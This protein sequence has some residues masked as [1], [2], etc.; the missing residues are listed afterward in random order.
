MPQQPNNILIIRLSSLGDV[1]MAIPAVRAIRNNFPDA[2]IS[3]LVE[4][5]VGEFLACQDFIDEVIRFPRGPIMKG[6]KRGNLLKAQRETG[7]FLR[8]LKKDEYDLIVVSQRAHA[9]Q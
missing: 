3:W 2:R 9:F 5:S 1:L 7:H 8:H 4:G 6:L